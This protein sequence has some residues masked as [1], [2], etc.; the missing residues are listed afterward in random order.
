[1][2]ALPEEK[3]VFLKI[4][5]WAVFFAGPHHQCECESHLVNAKAA[6]DQIVIT[7]IM[8]NPNA[9]ADATGEWFEV[10]NAGTATANLNG[11]TIKD[12][13]S[14]SHTINNDVIIP[15]GSYAVLGINA[16]TAVNGGVTLA[17][18]YSGIALANGDDEV[19][20]VRPDN[21]IA[22]EVHYDGGSQFP[23]PTGASMELSSAAS[24]NNVGANWA[25]ATE[26]MANGDKGTPGSGPDLAPPTAA[27]PIITEIMQNPNAVA[28]T[29]GEWFEI[30]NPGG[31][32]LN[33]N[34]WQI[35]DNGTDSFTITG[36]VFVTAGDFFILG[37]N[38]NT[39]TN[40]GITVDL[41]YSGFTLANGADEIILVRP[42]GTV[43]DEAAYD[44]GSQWPNPTG[45][46]MELSNL[47]A[48]N[49]VGSNWVAATNVL[50]S[51][52][53][54]TP[55][56]APDGS[57]GNNGGGNSAPVVNAGSDQT[58]T[59]GG[60][61]INLTLTG[62]ATDADNDPL[63]YSW[64]LISG[65]AANVSIATPGNASTAVT[66]T[67]VG[68]YTF[69][70]NAD[71]GTVSAGDQVNVNVRSQ[72][73]SS[74]NYNVYFGNLHAHSSYSDGNKGGD[75]NSDGAA[76]AFRYARDQAG[77]DW[78]LVA[79]HNHSDAGM[80]IND[81]NSG[82]QEAVNVNNESS[83]FV[84]LYGSEWGTISGG[85]HV[86]YAGDTL[87]GWEAGNYDAFVAKSDYPT[88]FDR[89]KTEGTFAH[90]CHPST[91]D[92]SGI[93]TNAYNAAW[94]E[95]VSTIAVK[96]G[97]AFATA[98]D[99]SEPSSSNYLSR[100]YDLLLKGYHLGP[101]GD[102]DTHYD[103]W[104]LANEQRTAVLAP[105]L[106]KADIM[107][108]LVAG[109]VY[110]VEDRNI[111]V[112]FTAT[113]NGNT[114]AMADTLVGSVGQGV[115][116]EVTATD[117]DG[118]AITNITLMGGII[119]GG[120]VGQITAA[121]GDTLVYNHVP[122]NTSDR[123]FF[124][125]I[126]NEA[127][128]QR[129]WTAPIW[130]E[131]QAGGPV[132]SAPV[133]DFSF[134]TNNRTA[135]F[136]D[137]S[138]DNDG[139]I[140]TWSWNFGDGSSSNAQNPSHTYAADGTY[141]VT[142]TVTDN[143]GATN[144]TSRSVSVSAPVANQAPNASF[145]F[146]TNDLAASFNDGSSDSD[147]SLVAWSWNFGDGT[148]SGAQNPNHTYAAD[149]TYTV[150]LTVT[151]NDGAVDTFSAQVSV[152]APQGPITVTDTVSGSTTGRSSEYWQVAVS[153]GTI[154]LSCTWTPSSRDL[155]L[156]IYDPNGNLVASATST[157]NPETLSYQT[158]G[159]SGTYT[160]EVYQ[161]TRRNSANYTLTI[162]RQP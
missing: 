36:D 159:V 11:W 74:G 12:N 2:R 156:Y 99:F 120:S 140:S 100:Y 111:I 117:P 150:T 130:I 52:D 38:G 35:K 153:G 127:D 161:Y 154:D 44:G 56:S 115:T 107:A 102:Q 19:I 88:L 114:A 10:F 51:G 81:W 148:T 151:D 95:A 144:S 104:G 77:L 30:H 32:D 92:F 157:S 105:S 26:T 33:L 39:A 128:G 122:A 152:Q 133:A 65:N 58:F 125:A 80:N 145:T 29:D 78:L 55:G 28:D 142:L 146:N 27:D 24:D 54:G 48:D 40:G 34:G 57:G 42:D 87:W 72:P 13:G 85:G 31:I 50:A 45:A 61:N 15:P 84:A 66:V 134:N 64:S 132:N 97:P 9:V 20:L 6:N 123:H 129:A 103:N 7:E 86:I 49:N 73:S 141:T 116:L 106:N 162:T 70:L 112:N 83:A 101:A 79:D 109:R 98:T 17:Y 69:Q 5:L 53:K 14:D 3:S 147:G 119:G 71:D 143:D 136:N 16:D 25:T 124:L 93:F 68:F 23:D 94:D 138:V 75:P 126:V 62:S 96:S 41:V 108:A 158:N 37:R 59:Y 89:I 121:G 8:Q 135:S 90:L 149:G 155:D 137:A 110:C 46:S 60:A 18:Q 91:S 139:T 1:M 43:A 76:A 63:T 113:F 22:D 21:S 82:V 4:F 47:S 160:I 131:A 118:E 67:A